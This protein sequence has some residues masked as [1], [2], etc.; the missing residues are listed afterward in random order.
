MT[1]ILGLNAFHP[2]ASA[3]AVCDG[4]VVAAV[5]EERLGLR[6]KHFAGFPALALR[7]VLDMAG[8]T[9]RDVDY[10]ALGSDPNANLAAKAARAAAHPL[11]TARLALG[12][13]ARR[14]RLRSLHQH[15]AAACDAPPSDCRFKVIKVEHHLAHL[16]SAFF[17]SPFDQAAGFSYDGAGDFAS[18]MY[19]RCRG[20]RVEIIR[21]VL[22]PHSIGYF[23]TALCQFIGFDRY[24]EEYKVMGLAAYGQ[25]R[26]L[27]FMRELLGARPGGG[28]ELSPQ[29]FSVPYVG[30]EDC[31]DENGE[32]VMPP[33]YAQAL[34]R[35]LGPPRQ[36]EAEI[37]QRDKDLAASCQ[38]HFE[39][40]ALAC[41]N[42]LHR[43]APS[44][45]LVAAGGCALNGVCNARL[46]RETPF[47]RSFLQPAASD[48]GTALGAALY[49]WNTVLG[50]PREAP[51]EHAFLGPGYSER[52]MED[53]LRGS[54][55][56]YAR[57][58]P[59]ALLQAA[60]EHLAA[61]H[62]VGWYQGRSEWG[63]RAL[64]NRSILAHPGWPEMKELINAKVKRR[65]PFRPFA[66]SILAEAV[67]EY[68]EQHIESPFMMH[69]VRIRPEKRQA[70]SAV[71]HADHT[72][73]LHTVSRAQ[74]PLYYDLIRAFAAR[75]G[76]PALL[77]TSFNENEP[78]VD[79]PAQAVECFLRTDLDALVLGDLVAVK[80]GKALPDAARRRGG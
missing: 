11:R 14:T 39:D 72:G 63:P 34:A 42:W 7:R 32:V 19:A 68:F 50:K 60:V 38:R 36:R 22:M 31:L 13:L 5:A 2:D 24:G 70:L 51:M 10:V 65:E 66:P 76:V 23:Y 56:H 37:S 43:Q 71:C 28:Y 45:N 67:P 48:D 29:Y 47:R 18:A 26:Y 55:F 41:V 27:D 40:A 74:N 80:P 46:L 75:T 25:P 59:E 79:T 21:R 33:F 17:A 73:R 69:V 16:A 20:G 53:A 61:G 15:V 77:N 58:A 78:I 62:V 44:E 1:L 30:Y 9:L 12:H 64:G 4:R 52:E 35:R 54:G 6:R 49:V 3:C 57:L 8:A